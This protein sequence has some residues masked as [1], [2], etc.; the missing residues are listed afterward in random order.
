MN[1]AQRNFS[2]SHEWASAIKPQGHPLGIGNIFK[3]FFVFFC[4]FFVQKSMA[5]VQ[6]QIMYCINIISNYFVQMKD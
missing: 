1:S 2:D 5:C 4:L 6:H 3:I